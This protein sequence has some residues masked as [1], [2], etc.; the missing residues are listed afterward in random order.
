M[1]DRLARP[2]L[3]TSPAPAPRGRAG[4]DRDGARGSGILVVGLGRF[5]SAL[6]LQLEALGREVLAVE[7]DPRLVAQYSG[8]VPL[9]EADA[10]NPEAL[11]QIAAQEFAVAVV[12]VGTFLE[13]SMLITGNLVDLGVPQIWAKAITPEHARILT[14]IGAH[15]VVYPEAD[16]GKRVAHLV[17][18]SLLDYIEVEEDFTIVKMRPP[19]ETIGFALRQ[20]RVRSRYGVTILGVKSPGEDFA[21]ATPE[22]VVRADDI[23]IVGGRPELLERFAAR[24]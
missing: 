18:G 22:T 5:G 19:T 16:A 11:A 13:A 7:R 8:R 20:S 2:D 3:P 21:S 4:K 15:H 14:R 24:P 9:V 23:V 10:T 6:A 17:S 1:A 12:G